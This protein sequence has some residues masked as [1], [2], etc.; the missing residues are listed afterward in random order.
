MPE[1]FVL[2]IPW[3]T[4]CLCPLICR[5]SET[6]VTLLRLSGQTGAVSHQEKRTQSDRRKH[7]WHSDSA[8]PRDLCSDHQGE[9][10]GG[11]HGNNG[12]TKTSEALK[13]TLWTYLVLNAPFGSSSSVFQLLSFQF[14]TPGP[15]DWSP[16]SSRSGATWLLSSTRPLSG[17]LVTCAGS[18]ELG[19]GSVII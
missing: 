2:S 9:R 8:L 17:L 14:G 12:K 1:S 18:R 11:W 19:G 13:P 16:G 15:R 3:R 6:W 7:V 5:K 4:S 10:G